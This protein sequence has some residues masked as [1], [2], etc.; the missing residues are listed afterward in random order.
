MFINTE[1]LY[2]VILLRYFAGGYFSV[3]EGIF[4]CCDI[5]LRVFISAEGIYQCCNILLRVFINTEGILLRHLSIL[6]GQQ[7]KCCSSRDDG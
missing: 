7:G 5:L 2:W 6:R 1:M 4:Q 3:L